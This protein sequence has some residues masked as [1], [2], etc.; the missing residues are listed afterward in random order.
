MIKQVRLR[1]E[2]DF[3]NL[4]DI[5]LI[6][7]S[8]DVEVGKL[9]SGELSLPG[10]SSSE[11]LT[12]TLMNIRKYLS[13]LSDIAR[14]TRTVSSTIS[15]AANDDLP[16]ML[17]I[18]AI[19]DQLKDVNTNL[20]NLLQL[21][22]TKAVHNHASKDQSFGIGT[23]DLYGHVKVTQ[24]VDSVSDDAGVAL[25]MD[26]ARNFQDQIN[27]KAFTSHTSVD[28]SNGIASNGIY[29]HVR[30]S[31]EYASIISGEGVAASQRGL[32]SVYNN[33]N[34]RLID[35]ETSVPTKAPKNHANADVS[36]YGGATGSLYGHV[37]LT[38]SFEDV[39]D[40][41]DK[42]IAASAK[43]LAEAYNVLKVRGGTQIGSEPP[44]NTNLLWIDTGDDA[45]LKY[46]DP[47]TQTWTTTT[48]VWG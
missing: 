31:G 23:T 37:K 13:N 39:D 7:T 38:D 28:G 15:G 14:L 1:S 18:D 11:M 43:A 34:N 46:F 25:G 19:E 29:G 8:D 5:H 26:V 44:E 12:T 33:A 4:V 22:E 2:D 10:N 3:G 36:I 48:A 47:D 32:N 6:N 21:I 45:V 20:E 35:L 24:D 16:N 17:V 41:A 30:L 9:L 42:S 40:G 27:G